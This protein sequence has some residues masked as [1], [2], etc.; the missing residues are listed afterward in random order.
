MLFYGYLNLESTK[1]IVGVLLL[2][3]LFYGYLNLES[4]KT[5][6]KFAGFAN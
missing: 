2:L 1:T 6:V 5:G 4:T 3:L